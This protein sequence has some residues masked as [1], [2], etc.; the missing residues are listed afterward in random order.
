[1]FVPFNVDIIDITSEN[2]E[3]EVWF[4]NSYNATFI[5]DKKEPLFSLYGNKNFTNFI[6]NFRKTDNLMCVKPPANKLTLFTNITKEYNGLY[7]F[8][9][10]QLWFR[11]PKIA[12]KN[13]KNSENF[14]FIHPTQRTFRIQ[15][16]ATKAGSCEI[17]V[18][19][20]LPSHI[21]SNS[22]TLPT[23]CIANIK[24]NSGNSLEIFEGLNEGTL[25][26]KLFECKQEDCKYWND[27]CVNGELIKFVIPSNGNLEVDL[28]RLGSVWN[29]FS[30]F[31]AWT[32]PVQ[33]VLLFMNMVLVY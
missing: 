9:P 6:G 17:H 18:V 11:N 10:V 4:V 21:Q 19:P 22:A 27:T 23:L 30:S 31:L 15:Q 14:H 32:I 28:Y 25:F 3:F 1:M 2:F 16:E 29:L 12:S 20:A 13:C 5:A 24:L 7:F 33:K 8:S 26:V